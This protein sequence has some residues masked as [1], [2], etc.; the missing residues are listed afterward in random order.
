MLT[1]LSST[2]FVATIMG[3]VTRMGSRGEV[4]VTV[5]DQGGERVDCVGWLHNR[6]LIGLW[7]RNTSRLKKNTKER[8]HFPLALEKLFY[9]HC[10]PRQ[11]APFNWYTSKRHTPFL[12][13]FPFSQLSFT[14]ESGNTCQRCVR[15][16]EM[17]ERG[18]EAQT[19]A[20]ENRN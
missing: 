20:G 2:L 19:G 15:L 18:G 1:V 14:K 6:N 10:G 17:A 3:V 12:K 11:L 13:L 7:K 16:L 9:V 4:L 5:R 8:R